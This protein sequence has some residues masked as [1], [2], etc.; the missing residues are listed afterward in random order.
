VV[1]VVHNARK[2]TAYTMGHE[3]QILLYYGRNRNTRE[4][5][6]VANIR[7]RPVAQ[8]G[9]RSAG[10]SKDR[11]LIPGRPIGAARYLPLLS[12]AQYV[13]REMAESRRLERS[14]GFSGQP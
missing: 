9:Q 1:A 5:V 4:S 8:V 2:S 12:F 7:R 13:G 10:G 11:H 14:E 3:E 6:E